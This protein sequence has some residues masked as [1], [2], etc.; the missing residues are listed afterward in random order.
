MCLR[1]STCP[2]VLQPV[3]S[4]AHFFGNIA[5][6]PYKMGINPPHECQYALGY[7]RPGSCAPWML[8]P[9]PLSVR[10]GLAEA[11]AIIGGAAL[12]P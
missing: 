7:Y 10:G 9:V 5:I 3:A 1:G 8:P 11:G 12:L 2:E 4:F 6:L